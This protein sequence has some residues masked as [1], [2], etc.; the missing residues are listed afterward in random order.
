M[1]YEDKVE[2]SKAAVVVSLTFTFSAF[3]I[4]RSDLSSI[5][6]LIGIATAF[7]GLFIDAGAMGLKE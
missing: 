1:T 3:I 2:L 7:I 4:P 6:A 5:Y